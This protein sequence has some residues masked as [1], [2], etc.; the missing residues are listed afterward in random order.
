MTEEE[1]IVELTKYNGLYNIPK[2]MLTKDFLKEILKNEENFKLIS[3]S[4]RGTDNLVKIL[5]KYDYDTIN[6]VLTDENMHIGPEW[7]TECLKKIKNSNNVILTAPTGAGKTNVMLKWAEEKK[8][9]PIYIT[10][11][12]KSLSNQRYREL[13]EKGFVVGLETGDIKNVPENCDYICCTQEIYTNK[14]SQEETTLLIDEFGYIFENNERARTYIDALHDSKAENILICSATMGDIVKLKEYVDKV[15]GRD[16]NVFETKD[17]LTKLSYKGK[18]RQENIKNA[19]VVA[20]SRA[21][22][23]S[24]IEE[25]TNQREDVDEKNKKNIDKLKQKYKIINTEIIED[26][27]KGV[28]GYYG[29]LLPKEKLF[30]EECFEQKC[31]DTVVGTD[32]LAMGVNFPVEN[33]VFAQLGKYYDEIISKN[34]FDQ[35]SGRAGRKGYYDEGKVYFCDDFTNGRGCYFDGGRYYSETKS[36]YKQLIVKKNENISIELTPK[37]KDVL[38]G[39]T[40]MD[41]EAKYIAEFST[42]IGDIGNELYNIENKIYYIQEEAF[43]KRVEEI[44][45]DDNDKAYEH[46]YYNDYNEQDDYYTGEKE[47]QEEINDERNEKR[48]KLMEK[49]GEFI[50]NI[51]QVYFPEFSVE[52]NCEIFADIVCGIDPDKILN[53]N[54][55]SFYDMLQ[56]RKY[57]KSLPKRYRKGLTKI[58]SMIREIDE[59][60]IDEARGS[61]RVEDIL[62]ELEQEN[63][64][65][66]TNI[67]KVLKNQETAMRMNK[68]ADILE[69]QLRIAEEYGLEDQ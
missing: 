5:D 57:V 25:L 12:I 32:A 2:E 46:N 20:F 21:N 30:I 38:Q 31:I 66:A 49:K 51:G 13:K 69:E 62:E 3:E 67:M 45:D 6:Q 11:P 63:R 33:V 59:T 41:E 64:L 36:L 53:N 18:M 27:Y 68:Q 15:S 10:A 65:N 37:I 35:I 17:R 24:V 39:K 48:Q 16:F 61:A 26:A 40:T 7:Q 23:R 56:F 29:A 14:Y 8:K 9:K 55:N 58:N 54:T 60:A 34:L 52:K 47:Q 44:L 4:L 22:I 42:P 43:E 1:A 19:L 50:E 28:A